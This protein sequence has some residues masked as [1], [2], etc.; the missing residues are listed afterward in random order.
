MPGSVSHDGG[1]EF[2]AAVDWIIPGKVQASL[3]HILFYG[4]DIVELEDI[5]QIFYQ[6]HPQRHIPIGVQPGLATIQIGL[7]ISLSLP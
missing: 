7:A 5:R 2:F 3:S 4:V 6:P 1:R